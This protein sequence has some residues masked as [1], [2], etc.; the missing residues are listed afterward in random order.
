VRRLNQR[1]GQSYRLPSEAEWEYAARAGTTTAYHWGDGFDLGRA[2]NGS[3]TVQ[4]G[5]YSANAFGLHDVHGNVGEWVR[6]VWHNNYE[7]APTDGSAR[8][9]G[10]D[11]GRRVLRGGSWFDAPRDL[12]SANRGRNTPGIRDISTGFRIARPL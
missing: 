11:E 2:N 5:R 6:D 1:T 9:A 10:G 8:I 7:G 12:R 3:R 4:V